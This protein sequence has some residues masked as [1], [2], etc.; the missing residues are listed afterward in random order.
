LTLLA[1]AAG[2][3]RPWIACILWLLITASHL[4][5]VAQS[6]R[7]L[8]HPVRSVIRDVRFGGSDG[9]AT[10]GLGRR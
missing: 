9:I 8:P 6:V 5:F 1:A 3:D 4:L 10:L 7:S 2:A